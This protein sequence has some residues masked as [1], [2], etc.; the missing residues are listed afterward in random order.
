MKKIHDSTA[1]YIFR[2]EWIAAV[3]SNRK[4]LMSRFAAKATFDDKN[5][6]IGSMTRETCQSESS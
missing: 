5:L 2:R 4:H 1:K 3:I 6:K